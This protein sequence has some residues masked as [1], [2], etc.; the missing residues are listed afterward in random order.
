MPAFASG[1]F[2]P[3]PTVLIVGASTRAAAWSTFR[4]GFLPIC[5]DAFADRDLYSVANV[6][7]VKDYPKSLPQDL[8]A[9]SSDCWMFVGAMENHR[10]L[11]KNL[12]ASSRF[13]PCCGPT[14][15]VLEQ[16]RDPLWLADRSKSLRCYPEVFHAKSNGNVPGTTTAGA[17]LRKPLASSGG[18]NIVL[19]EFESIAATHDEPSYWQKRVDGLPM[20]ALFLVTNSDVQLLMVSQQL[21]GESAAGAP[22]PYTYCGSIG[23][24]SVSDSLSYQLSQAARVLLDGLEY[25]GVLGL[26]FIWDGLQAWIVEVNPRYTASAELWELS[27]GR[28]VVAAHLRASGMEASTQEIAPP[29]SIS[30]RQVLGKLI[31]YADRP[32][33]STCFDRCL[34]PRNPWSLPWMADIPAT[35]SCIPVGAPI[36]TV[37]ASGPTADVCQQKLFRRA[38]RVR[39]WFREKT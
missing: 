7:P 3:R 15:E 38:E 2:P 39:S 17:W 11:L 12:Q 34:T 5:A 13:G 35:G 33:V 28:S 30:R 19:E 1:K 8:Q 26:D 18:R 22:S 14:C 29:E 6:V 21:I 9:F 36:C 24:C 16:L 10:H 23:P 37:Y 32:V 31:L 27:T 25:R 4:G 20:A